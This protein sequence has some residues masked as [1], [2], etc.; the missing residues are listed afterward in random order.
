MDTHLFAGFVDEM[1]KLATDHNDDRRAKL[2]K[3]F[4]E[5]VAV[6]GDNSL[7]AKLLRNR[8]D[9]DVYVTKDD[10]FEGS[11][12]LPKAHIVA[13]HSDDKNDGDVLAHELGHAALQHTLFGRSTQSDPARFAHMFAPAAGAIGGML[14]DPNA[15]MASLRGMAIP[16]AMSAP[17]IANEAAAS[18]KGH[19]LLKAEGATPEELAAYRKKLT[20]YG[21]TYLYNPLAGVIAYGAALLVKKVVGD[22]VEQERTKTAEVATK[23]LPHQQRVVDR[24]MRPDQTGLV[25]FHGLGSGK[26]L[27][28]IAAQDALGM[29]ASVV[30]PAALKDNYLKE[31]K[32][33]LEGTPQQTDM[34]TLQTIARRG[35]APKTPMLIVDEAHRL[36]DAGSQ[37]FKALKSTPAAKRLLLTGSPFYNHPADIAPLINLAANQRVL[38]GD[39]AEFAKQYITEKQVNPGFISKLKG[40]KPGTV[41]MLNKA[42]EQELRN[43]FGKYVDYHAGG[44]TADFPT[45]KTTNI[46][47]PMSG[48]Q[49]AVYDS[50]MD[51][52]PAWVRE[53]VKK[54][55]P[56]SKQEAT[57]LNAFLSATRQVSNS[58]SPFHEKGEGEAPKVQRAFEEMKKRLDADETAKGVVYSNFLEAGINPYK[59]RLQAAGIPYGEFTGAMKQHERDDLVRQYNE[60]KVRALLLSS[61]GG[62]GLD[63]KG[64]R[65]LQILEPHWNEEKLKQVIGRGARFKSHEALPE[66]QRNMEVQRFLA[67]RSPSG[68]FERMHLKAPGGSVD[69][70][71]TNRSKEKEQLLEQFR[72]LMKHP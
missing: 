53:K 30:V 31:Q 9:K 35:Q 20:G 24:L 69:E 55:L 2:D 5:E 36:R 1:K 25:A 17:T 14:A 60:G 6:E 37:S 44:G 72:G 56:P 18:I 64:T 3:H 29:H 67:T 22:I 46:N 21:A 57:Q 4:K 59:S 34:M 12:Y 15:G 47:V 26:T 32:K 10:R 27:T 68:V 40:T 45:V 8:K 50:M 42:K 33:H 49:L 54:N 7:Y 66:D 62:E 52:A 41:Q 39:Q 71:L 23:L 65:L 63:L 61:A 51:T 70:Y 28:S 19:E 13:M 58:T 48:K 43:V 38:P 11:G 16:F